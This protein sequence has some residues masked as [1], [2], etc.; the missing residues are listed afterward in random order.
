MILRWLKKVEVGKD[1]LCFVFAPALVSLAK[2]NHSL[3]S[4]FL[5]QGTATTSWRGGAVQLTVQSSP[6]IGSPLLT[7]KKGYIRSVFTI[8]CNKKL[9]LANAYVF[10]AGQREVTI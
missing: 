5:R 2:P 9:N 3:P 1:E 8:S 7:E 6:S 10:L 4:L